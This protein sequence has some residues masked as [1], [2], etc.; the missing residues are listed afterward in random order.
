MGRFFLLAIFLLI[1]L[2][3]IYFEFLLQQ[4]LLFSLIFVLF[5]INEPKELRPG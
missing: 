5:G 2:I 1:V 3:L 4:L